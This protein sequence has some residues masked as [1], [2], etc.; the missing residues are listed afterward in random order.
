M[1][2]VYN[3]WWIYDVINHMQKLN[4]THQLNSKVNVEIKI[5]LSSVTD[6]KHNNPTYTIKTN[7]R[8]QTHV[9]VFKI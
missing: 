6:R 4:K 9:E 5:Q 8:A 3:I 7:T 1:T 2:V